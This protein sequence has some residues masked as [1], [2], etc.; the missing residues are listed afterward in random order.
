MPA[1][2]VP[3]RVPGNGQRRLVHS[4]AVTEIRTRVLAALATVFGL[5]AGGFNAHIAPQTNGWWHGFTGTPSG[6]RLALALVAGY[7]VWRLGSR[8]SVRPFLGMLL[9][10]LP[11]VAAVTGLGSALLFFSSETM[12]LVFAILLSITL[13]DAISEIPGVEPLALGLV[14]LAFFL[15]VGRYL[16]G[17]AGPQGDEPHYLLIAE[18]LLRDG[19]VDLNNQFAERAFSRFTS[20]DLKPHTAPRS[21]QGTLY[22]V[23]TPGLSALVAPG[24]ALGGYAGARAVVSAVL[25]ISVAL[26]YFVVK[27]MFGPSAAGFAFLVATFASPLPIYANSLFPDSIAPLPVA[28]TLA[29]LVSPST[30]SLALSSGSIAVLPWLHP[31]FIPLAALLAF[32]I[33][34]RSGFSGW[35]AVAV[36]VPLLVS[37]GLLLFHFHA[38][39]GSASLSA[40]YGPGF[41]ADVS[42]ARIPFG[43]SALLLDRQFGLLLFC[44]VL[45]LGLFGAFDL[46]KQDR[47]IA[48][49]VIAALAVHLGVGGAFSM[50]WGGASPPARFLIGAMPALLLLC[51][52][53]WSQG[54]RDHRRALLTAASGFGF[55]LLWLACLAPRALHNRSDGSSG[56]LRLLAPTLRVDELTPGFVSGGSFWIAALWAVMLIAAMARPRI[57]LWLAPPAI[58]LAVGL[59]GTPLLDPFPAALRLLESWS[60]HRLVVGGRDDRSAFELEIPLGAPSWSLTAG[61]RQYSPRFSLPAGK[62]RMRVASR[63]ENTPDALNLARIS[64]EGRDVNA[65]SLA[66]S[67]IRA[68]ESVSVTDF[69]IEDYQQRVN[70]RADG[71]QSRTT[72]LSVRLNPRPAGSP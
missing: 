69:D 65:P 4:G 37:G 20:A 43:A 25:A 5:I 19:D 58:T 57:G 23:H 48:T 71:Y 22:A 34:W 56:L 9:G 28:A 39:F 1:L 33:W 46:W 41:A 49:T 42:L 36:G 62:W 50:W 44:P 7:L 26:I 60:D 27:S 30:A 11:A 38:L 52:A 40:A 70:L 6:L 53:S 61:D 68:D 8:V 54:E 13:R 10:C 18:S 15:L 35:R 45:L 51:A 59:A 21:P 55:G 12:V 66:T 3:G 14:A 29:F 67:M 17:P 47:L 31:R 72:V 16:P 2:P 24:Y 63:S 32:F 64:I